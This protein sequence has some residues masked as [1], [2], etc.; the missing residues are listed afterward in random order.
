MTRVLREAGVTE[1]GEMA[2]LADL[3]EALVGHGTA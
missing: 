2:W 3:V 1:P